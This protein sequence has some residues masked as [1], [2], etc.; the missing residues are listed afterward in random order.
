MPDKLQTPTALGHVR[1]VDM[2][3]MPAAYAGA[4]LGGLGADVVK[5]EPLG[6]DPHRLLPPFAGDISDAERSLPF[7]NAN[8]NKRSIVLDSTDEHGLG[9]LSALLDRKSVV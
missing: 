2:G 8:L 9:L 7:L 5:V 6:G 3:G 4:Y 1:V